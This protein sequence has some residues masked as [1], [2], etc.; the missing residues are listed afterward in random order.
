VAQIW[1]SSTR[2]YT[3][4]STTEEGYTTSQDP[5]L[6]ASFHHWHPQYM[7]ANG[8][9]DWPQSVGGHNSQ[10]YTVDLN[11]QNTFC[12]QHY[13]ANPNEW[14]DERAWFAGTNG[15]QCS[16]LLFP[17]AHEYLPLIRRDPTPTQTPCPDC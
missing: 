9:Q 14:G 15:Q 6:T 8:F 13:G 1:S 5:Y 2:I 3:A 11:S 16:W 7:T 10:I 17:S 4:T 12:P